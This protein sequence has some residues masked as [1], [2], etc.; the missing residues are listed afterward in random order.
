MDFLG[1]ACSTRPWRWVGSVL[2]G[3]AAVA[4]A[5]GNAVLV[6]G[7]QPARD[8]DFQHPGRAEESP[9]ALIDCAGSV[10]SRGRQQNEREH[11]ARHTRNGEDHLGIATP[12]RGAGADRESTIFA[13]V[14]DDPRVA[15]ENPGRPFPRSGSAGPEAQRWYRARRGARWRGTGEG[16]APEPGRRGTFR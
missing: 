3:A 14:V 8:V 1:R 6:E 10:G 16:G 12:G 5:V 4:T 2:V 11:G 7:Q 15:G 9:H 13:V